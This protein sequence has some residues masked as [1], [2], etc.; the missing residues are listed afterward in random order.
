MIPAQ[1]RELFFLLLCRRSSPEFH[2]Y[3]HAYQGIARP[4]Y[5]SFEVSCELMNGIKTDRMRM[6]ILGLGR[7]DVQR[8][9]T[10]SKGKDPLLEDI[11]FENKK[12]ACFG[13]GLVDF[14]YGQGISR[15]KIFNEYGHIPTQSQKRKHIRQLF[16]ILKMSSLEFEKDLNLFESIKLSS[17][18][19]D[20]QGQARIKVYYGP[21]TPQIMQE[22]FPELINRDGNLNYHHL[23]RNDLMPQAFEICARYG[24]QRPSLKVNMKCRRGRTIPYL[25]MFDNKR[26]ASRFFVDFYRTIPALELTYIC[27]EW[28]PIQKTQFYFDALKF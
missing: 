7:Q 23:E 9:M 26:E 3:I 5:E 14:S 21:F 18:D 4:P 8:W 28:D 19:W 25:K 27:E 16:S 11:L 22:K 2:T 20:L 10:A 12:E 24:F 1:L 17:I 6:A 13:I 15:A